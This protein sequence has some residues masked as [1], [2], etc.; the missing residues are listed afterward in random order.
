MSRIQVLSETLAHQIAAGEVIERPASVLKELIENSIDAQSTRIEIYMRGGGR[1][2]VRVRDNGIGMDRADAEVAFARH[3]TSKIRQ[4]EDLS[5]IQTLGFRGEALPSIASVSRLTLRSRSNES[6]EGAGTEV[7]LEGG[8]ICSIRDAAWPEG[9]EVDVQDLFFNVPARKKF[10]KAPSTELSHSMRLV[11]QYAVI[12]PEIYFEVENEQGKLFSVPPV[13]SVRERIFQIYGREFVET[14]VPLDETRGSV[15]VHGFTSLPHEQRSNR[16][17]QFFFVNERMVRD[18]TISAAVAAAYRQLIPAGTFPVVLL[19]IEL[20][21]T[22][23]DVNVHPAKTEIR[24]R[25]SSAIFALIRSAIDKGLLALHSTP[26]YPQDSVFIPSEA[27]G[28]PHRITF[29]P[30]ASRLQNQAALSYQS[31][32]IGSEVEGRAQA[33]VVRPDVAGI[34]LPEDHLS[35]PDIAIQ[36]MGDNRS[37]EPPRAMGQ[38]LNSFIIAADRFGLFIIDQHVAHERV[39]YDQ[40]LRQ[41]NRKAVA[42]QRLLVPITVS[43]P[44]SRRGLIAFLLPELNSG[45][46]EAEAFGDDIII[47]AVPTV[48]RDADVKLI[49]REILDG[50]EIPERGAD[51]G[52]LRK[53]IA[54]AMAC[55]AAIKINTPLTP[56]KTQW[57][58]DEL[59]R[60]ENPTTCPHGR[61]VLF[62]L[63]LYEILRNFKRI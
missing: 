24:F 52:E 27:T 62:R 28:G 59:Y 39:L 47:Q 17:S 3:A 25:D 34:A 14:L 7:I 23:I 20:P 10:I 32:V 56:E 8:K 37:S 33:P 1:Q 4:V 49:V 41:M 6:T 53:K 26:E 61:P 12:H 45:G 54:V 9:T 60:T 48:A 31:L 38:L 57:L 22:E 50:L 29:G 15:R 21:P 43:V 30:F 18:K 11:A 46:F 55:R 42:V 51:V 44:A 2:R 13:P 19:F 36:P 58:L 40:A 35:W 16:Y 63:G 5:Q